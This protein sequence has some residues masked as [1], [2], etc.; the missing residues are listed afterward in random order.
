MSM[1]ADD[2]WLLPSWNQTRNI[3]ADDRFPEDGA[4]EDVTNG[5]VGRLPHLLQLEF[6]DA[7]L[8]GSDRCALDADVVLQ[9]GIS[10][11]DGD[12]IV[13]LIAVLDAQVERL[14]FDVQERQN[15]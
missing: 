9:N 11:I 5:A 14:Q 3:L 15:L 4:T 10:T 1:T 6:L 12:L 8:I 2:D 13:G 7:S